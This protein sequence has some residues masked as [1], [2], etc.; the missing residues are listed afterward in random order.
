MRR[1]KLVLAALGFTLAAAGVTLD[2]RP[3]IWG[4]LAALVGALAVRLW[5]RRP[6]DTP[7]ADRGPAKGRT[8]P[9]A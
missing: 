9:P 8:S 3:L 1:L 6:H 2:H 4:A 5:E 7:P